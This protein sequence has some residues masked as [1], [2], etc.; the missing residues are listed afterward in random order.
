[1]S[2]EF[3]AFQEDATDG[4]PGTWKERPGKQ[5]DPFF[6]CSAVKDDRIVPFLYH[7]HPDGVSVSHLVLTCTMKFLRPAPVI[8]GG[9]PTRSGM[10][11][12][13]EQSSSHGCCHAER[14]E[15]G[16]LTEADTRL[17]DSGCQGT[18]V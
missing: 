4:F 10:G 6:F 9:P 5:A 8:F 12:Q 7:M 2:N 1:M 17:P 11:R 16:L 15:V 14:E 3:A 18:S 13:W